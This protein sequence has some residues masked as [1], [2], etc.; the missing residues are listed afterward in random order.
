MANDGELARLQGEAATRAMIQRELEARFAP[1]D[2]ELRSANDLGQAA[3]MPEIQISPIQGKLLQVLAYACGARKILEI[4]ALAGYS[5]SWLARAL[6]LDGKLITLEVSDKHAEVARASYAAAGVADRAEVRVGPAL[7]T[8]PHLTSEAPFDLIFIDAD[9]G[10]Y[11][12]YLDWAVQLSRLGTII[13]ADNVIRYGR[14]FQSPPP[15]E[16]AAGAA[17]YNAKILAHP[18][19]VSVAFAMDDDGMDGY[20]I[21]VVR[22]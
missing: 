1:E 14:A 2:A 8:L 5:G 4:G 3:G 12:A 16:S 11:P 10:N 9:K 18:R 15:D 21:S 19:L 13:V 17:A 7:E 20:A 22:P 6:P